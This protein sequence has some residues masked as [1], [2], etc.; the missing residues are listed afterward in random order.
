[1]IKIARL[2][3]SRQHFALRGHDFT[4]LSI[5]ENDLVAVV[6]WQLLQKTG[7]NREHDEKQPSVEKEVFGP[8]LRSM[9]NSLPVKNGLVSRLESRRLRPSRTRLVPSARR[10]EDNFQSEHPSY[11]K[12][13]VVPSINNH[14]HSLNSGLGAGKQ[15][16]A[17][18]PSTNAETRTVDKFFGEALLRE[19][20]S[21]WLV[22]QFAHVSLR[23]ASHDICHLAVGITEGPDILVR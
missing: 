4:K 12:S 14:P 20:P 1:M 23:F 17:P 8:L 7:Y 10:L 19:T 16:H 22:I 15:T 9:Q 18:P 2:P 6:F 5:H 21:S 3:C 11:G 13:Q